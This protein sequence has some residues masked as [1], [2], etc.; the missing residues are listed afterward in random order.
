MN[1]KM[2]SIAILALPLSF[3]QEIFQTYIFRDWE[4]AKFL[5]VAVIVDT[6]CGLIKSIVLNN[7]SSSA[8]GM[9]A[10]KI[11]IYSAVLILSHV[12]ANFS[13]AGKKII[14]FE[15]FQYFACSA[16]LIREAIS[17]VENIAVIF[18]GLLPTSILKRLK[19]FNSRT[20][21]YDKK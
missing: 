21:D 20:G 14:S 12:M 18:P 3:L 19:D 10:K 8:W 16:L 13:I 9:I 7:V 5:V 15:W 17:I 2:I 1:N 6:M 11:I 4:F